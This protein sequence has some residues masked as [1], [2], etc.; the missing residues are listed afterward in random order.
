MA[1]PRPS[2]VEAIG[3]TSGDLVERCGKLVP[4][5]L[6]PDPVAVEPPFAVSLSGGGWRAALAAVGTLRFLADASLLARVRY[7]SSV[8]GG[9][10][11]AGVLA[12]R[13]DALAAY[14]FAPEQVDQE[15]V[16]P[17]LE[18]VRDHSL[19]WTLLRSGPRVLLGKTRT[20]VLAD[21][22]D[23]W[24]YDDLRLESLPEAC[25]FTIN[26]ANTTTGV[27][28]GFERNT[29]GDYVIGYIPTAATGVR[30]AD[31]VAASAAVPGV[32]A[33]T[34]FGD[35]EF[36]C[37]SGRDVRLLD[38][39]VYDNLGLEA[40]DDLHGPCLVV[41]S[42][43]GVFRTRFFGITSHI[44]ILRDLKRS[45]ELL[46]RQA[47]TIR[48]RTMVE[49]FR[50]WEDAPDGAKPSFARLG[51]LFGLATTLEPAGE[52]AAGR[53]EHGENRIKLA[54]TK[55]TFSRFSHEVCE[56]LIYR[57]WW[58]AGAVLSKFHR[59]LLPDALPAWRALP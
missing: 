17:L 21:I 2:R 20:D 29:M 37:G 26:A 36:P 53:P 15:V 7:V 28:F 23:D 4:P 55:T 14:Q 11:A 59:E 42:A 40:F 19:T 1:L 41:L 18:R 30:L 6:E 3:T 45:E 10:I 50:A 13:Y 33:A 51:V 9:S 38:G 43:G 47:T 32:F 31:A 39:G 16:K 57:G 49:R 8:S 12:A 44:P 46:Y 24:F 52:W 54:L 22:L 5:R 56:Q 25:R 58:L 27:N 35:L 34:R 48:T